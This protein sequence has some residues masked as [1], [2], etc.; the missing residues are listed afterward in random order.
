MEDSVSSVAPGLG[1]KRA[2]L[3]PDT[4]STVF[5]FSNLAKRRKLSKAREARALDRSIIDDLLEV[6]RE[7]H[8]E[9]HSS[10][11]T[12]SATRDIEIQCG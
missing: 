3:K 4:V 9:P 1:P 12:E 10:K 11:V 8:S 5:C 2:T 7:P 6:P